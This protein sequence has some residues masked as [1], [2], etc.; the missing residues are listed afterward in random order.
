MAFSASPLLRP[1]PAVRALQQSDRDSE[2]VIGTVADLEEL[3]VAI[4]QPQP[5]S[6]GPQTVPCRQGIDSRGRSRAV[7]LDGHHDPVAVPHD[8]DLDLEIQ[9]NSPTADCC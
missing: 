3:I 4:E 8:S 7:V 2:A 6:S 5:L 1:A 9:D